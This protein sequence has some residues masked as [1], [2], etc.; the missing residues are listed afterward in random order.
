MKKLKNDPKRNKRI[1][2]TVF[3][4]VIVLYMAFI[5]GR[6][7]WQNYNVNQE[8][9]DLEQEVI[10]LRERNQR[11]KNLVIYYQTD[12][13]LEKE[14][15]RK[16]LKKM[17]GEKVLALPETEY[18]HQEPT[19]QVDETETDKYQEPNYKLWIKYIFG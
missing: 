6:T 9:A 11:L 18:S 13:Y 7:L 4:A 14:A 16:L 19:E 15:R 17:P 2:S 8:I 10:E 1:W 12:S 5:L 3:F